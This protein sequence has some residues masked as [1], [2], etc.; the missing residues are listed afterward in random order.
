MNGIERVRLTLAGQTADRVPLGFYAVDCDTIEK[1]LGRKTFVR[2]KVGQQIALWNGRRQEVAESLKHD[3]VEFYRKVELCDIICCKEACLLPPKDYQP[4][5]VRQ[6]NELTWEDEFERVFKVSELSN[7]LICVE[8]PTIKN[9]VYSLT[10][11]P[12]PSSLPPQD[13]SIFEAFDYLLQQLGGERFILG[14]GQ[15]GAMP[16]LGGVE[17]GLMAYLEFPETVRAAIQHNIAYGN[18]RDCQMNRSGQQGILVEEDYGTTRASM[19]SPAMFRDFC[20]QALKARVQHMKQTSPYVFLHSCGYTWELV[21][22]FIDAGINAYQSLQTGTGMDLE[23]LKDRFDSK[24][25]FWGGIAVEILLK[26]TVQEVRANVRQAM[27]VAK[28]RR[29]IILGPSHSIAY[30]IPYENFMALL[31]EFDRYAG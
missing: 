17:E 15:L 20:F 31:E 22:M 5:K 12:I 27:T 28:R 23:K 4:P 6:I 7:E 1:V 24:I 16:K 25:T 11:F 21:D 29:G 14:P 19:L 3:T 2:D 30:G 10:D 18:L 13:E 8:D 26:G 9:K